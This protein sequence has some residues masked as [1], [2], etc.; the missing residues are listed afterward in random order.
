MKESA[1]LSRADEL[2]EPDVDF[3]YWHLADVPTTLGNV[4]FSN[5]PFGV[6]HFQTIHRTSG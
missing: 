4:R 6:K 2:V 5:R 1:L 3:R